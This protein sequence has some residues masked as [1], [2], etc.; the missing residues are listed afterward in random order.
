MTPQE[1]ST[2]IFLEF[3]FAIEKVYERPVVIEWT[4]K[5]RGLLRRVNTR[6]ESVQSKTVWPVKE[7]CILEFVRWIS[8][9]KPVLYEDWI[10]PNLILSRGSGYVG[11]YLEEMRRLKRSETDV[12]VRKVD[13][14]VRVYFQEFPNMEPAYRGRCL[15]LARMEAERQLGAGKTVE[16]LTNAITE[17]SASGKKDDPRLVDICQSWESRKQRLGKTESDEFGWRVLLFRT[18]GMG[19]YL[20]ARG[21]GDEDDPCR[22]EKVYE[23]ATGRPFRLGAIESL[24]VRDWLE[25]LLLPVRKEIAV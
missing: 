11:E 10:Q 3:E 17:F 23:E 13:E 2:G 24:I 5:L 22:F 1:Q 12:M 19:T 20:Q 16:Y 21:V 6:L 14:V 4:P 8:R 7:A 25:R 15:Y 9:Y 18:E